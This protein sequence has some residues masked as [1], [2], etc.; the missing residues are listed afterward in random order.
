MAVHSKDFHLALFLADLTPAQKNAIDQ[1]ADT[2]EEKGHPY[3]IL[4]LTALL[5]YADQ[6]SYDASGTA[7]IHIDGEGGDT[8][9][10]PESGDIARSTLDRLW[11]DWERVLSL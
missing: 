8:I 6:G 4:L 11:P 5:Y 10:L 9:S 3:I 1:M 7:V 2:L